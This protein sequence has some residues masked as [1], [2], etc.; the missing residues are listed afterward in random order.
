MKSFRTCLAVSALAFGAATAHAQDSDNPTPP[1][2]QATPT[3]TEGPQLDSEIVVSGQLEEDAIRDVV[4]DITRRPRTGK[5]VAQFRAPV[6]VK[7][8]GMPREYAEIM[9]ARIKENVTAAGAE[10]GK[11]DC[12]LNS[13]VAVVQD[14]GKE[15]LRLQDDEPWIFEGILDYEFDRIVNETGGARAWHTIMIRDRFGR[16]IPYEE[17][18]TDTG[19]IIRV[20]VLQSTGASRIDTPIR[21]DLTGAVVLIDIAKIEGKTFRQLADYASFRILASSDGEGLNDASGIDSI[22]SLF[23]DVI[24]PPAGLTPFDSAYLEALYDLRY[25][26]RA[27][28]LQNATIRNFEEAIEEEQEQA[29]VA[30]AEQGETE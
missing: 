23:S 5:P 19:R 6:C 4:K 1:V 11:P 13:L 25:T 3:E 18:E 10:V 12:D 21:M 9:E 29:K 17:I 15:V 28:A 16:S 30:P 26:A 20:P 14:P 22:M 7:V 8:T 24:E 2:E 27:G